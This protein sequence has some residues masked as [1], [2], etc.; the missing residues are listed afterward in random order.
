M[1]FSTESG[2][3]IPEQVWDAADIPARGELFTGKPTFAACPLV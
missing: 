2:Q 3:L 1:E